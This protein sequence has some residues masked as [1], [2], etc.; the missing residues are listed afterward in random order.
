[1]H[2]SA[3]RAPWY[4]RSGTV[5]TMLSP[6]R[7]GIDEQHPALGSENIEFL[8]KGKRLHA[9]YSAHRAER[10]LVVLIHGWE[11]HASAAYMD[12]TAIAL[13]NAGFSVARLHLKDHGHTRSWNPELFNGSMLAEHYEAVRENS[14][15]SAE[16]TWQDIHWAEISLFA[17]LRAEREKEFQDLLELRPSAPLSILTRQLPPWTGH[18]LIGRYLLQQ[19]RA[20]LREKEEHFPHLYNFKKHDS[21]RSGPYLTDVLVQEHS[22]FSFLEDYFGTYTLG[23]PFFARIDAVRSACICRRSHYSAGRLSG[24]APCAAW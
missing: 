21:V 24:A 5:Q 6:M 8:V 10:A 15:E 2:M 19:W 22:D 16:S 18:P 3:Y 1:M 23:S 17:L 4:L 9:Y 20:S 12:R 13:Y 7:T 14:P 11:G